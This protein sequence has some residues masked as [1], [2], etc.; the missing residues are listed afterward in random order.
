MEV[1]DGMVSLAP[2]EIVR[3]ET[4]NFSVVSTPA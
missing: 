3:S 1:S 2:P 4:L